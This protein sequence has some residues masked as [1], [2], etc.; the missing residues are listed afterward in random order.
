MTLEQIKVLHAKVGALPANKVS[1]VLL[2]W[3][4]ATTKSIA[5]QERSL[6][7]QAKQEANPLVA[8]CGTG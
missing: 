5:R 7:C 8:A 4:N 3:Y 1:P 2:R 6:A